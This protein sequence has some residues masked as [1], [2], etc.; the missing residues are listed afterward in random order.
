MKLLIVF[1]S[2]FGNTERLAREIADGLAQ[3]GNQP[4]LLDVRDVRPDDLV[5]SDLLVVGA[6]THAFSLSRPSTRED[7]VR[8]G[9]D[10]SRATLG[11]REWLES[12]DAARL[13][14]GRPRVAVFDSR[15]DKVRRLP[16]SAAK[17]AAKTLRTRGFDLLDRPVSFYVADVQGPPSPGELD[18]AHEWGTHLF[19]L[20]RSR[21]HQ[22]AP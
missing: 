9:A 7:A 17:R 11:V 15:V 14:A 19:G 6:P 10:P 5:G 12:L 18:R 8:Q 4:V 21:Q 1:E 22:S 20:V 2:M 16:G 3:D 13:P